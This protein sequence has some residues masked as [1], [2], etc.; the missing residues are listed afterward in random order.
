MEHVLNR[1]FARE[2]CRVSFDMNASD[3]LPSI[4]DVA[5][6]IKIL[7][8]DDDPCLLELYRVMIGDWR[9][10]ILLTCADSGVKAMEW[11]EKECPDF[12][13]LDMH[14]GDMDGSEVI[15]FIRS[16]KMHQSMN[17]VVVSGA[18][19]VNICSQHEQQENYFLLGKPI[20]FRQL[21]DFINLNSKPPVRDI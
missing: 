17:I 6:L 8:V 21:R 3:A 11:L 2:L 5:R 12:L 19:S 16:N 18:E 13:I 1:K 10:D 4:T 20:D 15:Q 7:V 14:L 9:S